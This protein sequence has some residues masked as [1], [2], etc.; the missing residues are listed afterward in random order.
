MSLSRG[1][2][3]LELPHGGIRWTVAEMQAFDDRNVSINVLEYYAV[4]FYV[5]LWSEELR[6]KVVEVECDNTAAVAWLLKSRAIHTPAVDVLVKIFTI[7]TYHMNI[8]VLPSHIP[9]VDN[10]EADY[11]SR[12]LSF[13]KQDADE[14]I[15]DLS[16]GGGWSPGCSRK[17][18][19][20]SLLF[21]CVTCP[22]KMDGQQIVQVLTLLGTKHG[23]HIATSLV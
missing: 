9:G 11:R 23:K 6:G 7:F 10:T 13:L 15:M 18:L 8:V 17:D 14:G 4:V 12:S 3:P 22:E 20:R 21:N 1:G 19:C 2:K 5:L 16:E